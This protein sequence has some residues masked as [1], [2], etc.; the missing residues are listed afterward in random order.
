MQVERHDKRPML[1][2]LLREIP[3]KRTIIF[4][5]SRAEADN[6]DD[7]LYNV[8][9]PVVSI[10]SDRTQLEREDAMR[11]FR[12]GSSPILVATGVTARGIDVKN[13]GHVINFDL[14]S[15]D[16]GGIEEYTHRIGTYKKMYECILLPLADNMTGRTGRIGHRGIAT[17]FF[18]DRD[19]PIASVLARTLLETGQT[20]PDFLEIHRP[21]GD[22][23]LQF[24]SDAEAE[25]GAEADVNDNDAPAEAWGTDSSAP[26][27]ASKAVAEGNYWDGHNQGTGQTAQEVSVGNPVSQASEWAW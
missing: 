4:V 8:G 24:D 10:H 19:E 20:L 12:G 1:L 15:M 23:P 17:S 9:L 25:A 22:Q 14:P 6:L 3:G 21:E 26:A 7:F 2:N 16:Y 11:R 18:T 13:V 5:N 27:E